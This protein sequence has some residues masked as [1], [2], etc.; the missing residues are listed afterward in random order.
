M[1]K[2]CEI[3]QDLLPLYVD[4]ALKA[5]TEEYV[6]EHLGKCE[7]CQL[8]K[9][10]LL[11]NDNWQS[12]LNH[13][14]PFPSETGEKEFVGRIRSWK[15]RT[16]IVGIVLILLVSVISWM[17]GKNFQEPQP[18]ISPQSDVEQKTS[19]SVPHLKI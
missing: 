10:E 7:V 3:V 15:K 14:E 19:L 4:G 17:I 12:T 1:K 6:N 2:Q 5:H 9:Q 8:V 11:Q 18:V 13:R 16:S